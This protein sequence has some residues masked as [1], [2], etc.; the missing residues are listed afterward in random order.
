MA[1]GVGSIVVGSVVLGVVVLAVL[2]WLLGFVGTLITF[3]WGP[4]QFKTMESYVEFG[5]L[6]QVWIPI[7]GTPA[8]IFGFWI[9]IAQREECN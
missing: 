1:Y 5:R 3:T 2:S 6:L 7:I 4:E 9:W 8:F